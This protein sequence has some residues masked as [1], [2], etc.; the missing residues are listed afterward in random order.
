MN[1]DLLTVKFPDDTAVP[2]LRELWR[3]AFGD[4]E[5]FIDCF[6]DNAYDKNRTLLIEDSD[7]IL[8][9][10]YWFDCSL[11]AQKLAY[12]Y[13][14]ATAKRARGRGLCK[15]LM[16]KAH[17]I[18]RERGY[19]SAVLVPASEGLFGFY[20]RLGYSTCTY[21]DEFFA[22][23]STDLPAEIQQ[24]D[25][26]EYASLRKGLLPCFSVIQ[27]GESLD[28]LGAMGSFY[29]L[30]GT[31]LF[32]Y[33]ENGVLTCRE[34]LGDRSLAG[35]VLAALGARSG[36]FRIPGK[37]K[38]FCMHLPLEVGAKAPEYFGLAFD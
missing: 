20:E 13:G 3:E 1:I 17:E 29:K 19:F 15:K 33:T 37:E 22:L 26:A 30:G 10:L 12:L 23:P 27:E 35:A 7:G 9:V 11:D 31:I 34:Y 21:I 28:F 14:I 16:Q 4:T 32:A 18:L 36:S 6:F 25:K 24:I 8:S 2:R 38:P 5:E